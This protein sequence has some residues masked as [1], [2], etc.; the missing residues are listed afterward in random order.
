MR[1][2]LPQTPTPR[3]NMVPLSSEAEVIRDLDDAISQG[4]NSDTYTH[5][6]SIYIYAHTPL[7]IHIPRWVIS[8]ARHHDHPT[9]LTTSVGDPRQSSTL[10]ISPS[11]QRDHILTLP[12][13][14]TKSSHP[15]IYQS[16]T[17]I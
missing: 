16:Q 2:P 12:P 5:N 1:I 14:L 7:K 4:P 17:M 10:A 9:H 3:F 11:P 15:L 8:Q 6:S 13:L